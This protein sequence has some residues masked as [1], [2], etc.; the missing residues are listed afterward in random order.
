MAIGAMIAVVAMLP[1]PMLDSVTA[2]AKN[3]I[4]ITPALPLH[5]RTARA[6]MRPSVPL[7]FAIPNSSVTPTRL[8]SRSIGNVPMTLASGMPPM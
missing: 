6:A 3:M 4:G 7:L 5:I 1:G 2:I 8:S